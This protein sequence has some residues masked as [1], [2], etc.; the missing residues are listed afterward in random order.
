MKRFALDQQLFKIF[1]SFF[2]FK[3][4]IIF[5]SGINYIIDIKT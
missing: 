1:L 3:I 2:D 4:L 5:K